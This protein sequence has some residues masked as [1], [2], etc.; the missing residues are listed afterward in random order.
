MYLDSLDSEQ[1]CQTCWP[2]LLDDLAGSSNLILRRMWAGIV[3]HLVECL[4]RT[5]EALGSKLVAHKLGRP[6]LQA[7][8]LSMWEVG[9][10]GS[11]M[12]GCLEN[13]TNKWAVEF[14]P[15]VPRRTLE[16]PG[17]HKLRTLRGQ[18]QHPLLPYM[19]CDHTLDSQPQEDASTWLIWSARA[20]SQA[21][22]E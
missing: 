2:P 16:K 19:R 10:R 9:A 22:F 17:A 5:H 21:F 7:C 4:P 18:R 6:V 8:N 1:C 11:E 12:Q 15:E 3:A 20:L 14:G 13:S